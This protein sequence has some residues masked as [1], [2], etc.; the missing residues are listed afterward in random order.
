M[1]IAG[2]DYSSPSTL[3]IPLTAT[4]ANAW[5]AQDAQ[6]WSNLRTRKAPKTVSNTK[7]GALSAS[8]IASGPAFDAAVL[9]AVYSLCL[10]RRQ[11]PAQVGSIEDAAKLQPD[12]FHISRMFPDSAIASTYLALHHTPLYYLL[13]VS[14]KSWVFNKKVTNLNA[15]TEHQKLL[16]TWRSSSTASIATV[17]AARALKLFLGLQTSPSQGQSKKAEICLTERM[18]LSDIS[19]Y[20]GIYICT[21]IC[22]AFGLTG[23]QD[24]S[25]IVT[26]Q[27]ATKGWILR[28]AC[29]EPSEIQAEREQDGAQG[30]VGLVRGMLANDCLGGGNI[31]FADA[32]NVLRRLEDETT[33]NC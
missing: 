11:N 29:Q 17:F 7:L 26:A 9:L 15:F 32:L 5:E 2:L 33:G 8:D 24:T 31:L 23:K 20:W 10:P 1:P 14:G 22:W 12:I 25:N 16:A 27:E 19:D 3:P 4:T 18:S 28:V 30:V 13:S 6:S 21:L